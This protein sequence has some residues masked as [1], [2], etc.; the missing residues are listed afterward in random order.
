MKAKAGPEFLVDA[1]ALAVIDGHDGIGQVL[2]A[3]ATDDAIRRAKAHGVGVVAVRN[4][5]H[6]GMAFHYTC[7]RQF[8]DIFDQI[9]AF[10]RGRP[11]NVVN[12][13]V[14]EQLTGHSGPG[15]R[16]GES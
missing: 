9:V 5:N 7:G 1:G 3:A 8:S 12:P 11:I 15:E 2:A 16:R 13:E 4:S 10:A 6:F 14:L